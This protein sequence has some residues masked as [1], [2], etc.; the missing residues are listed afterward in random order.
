MRHAR[1][2]GFHLCSSSP[3]LRPF[4]PSLSL[5]NPI[6]TQ[7]TIIKQ[8]SR[9]LKGYS[10]YFE[11]TDKINWDFGLQN[12]R[13]DSRYGWIV[14]AMDVCSFSTWDLTLFNS[15]FG[16]RSNPSFYRINVFLLPLP[17]SYYVT[18][19]AEQTDE[20]IYIESLVRAHATH[21]CSIHDIAKNLASDL[22]AKFPA[23]K[24]ARLEFMPDIRKNLKIHNLFGAQCTF[25]FYNPSTHVKAPPVGFDSTYQIFTEWQIPISPQSERVIK[26]T[27]QTIESSGSTVYNQT[28]SFQKFRTC[29]S[30]GQVHPTFS[31]HE[32][33]AKLPEQLHY[34][35]AE[36]E[37]LLL[38]RCLFHLAD[39]QSPCKRLLT[40]SVAM[41]DKNPLHNEARTEAAKIL[42]ENGQEFVNQVF[43]SCT[44][45]LDRQQYEQSQRNL[46]SSEFLNGRHRAYLALGSNLGNRVELIESAV[47]EISKRGLVVLRTSALYE[48]KPMYLENQET[49]INGACEVCSTV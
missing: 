23:V 40:A 2:F 27:L 30:F 36:S 33:V 24:E 34:D 5:L 29:Y 28:P 21:D 44:V 10:S 26:L 6:R 8:V 35:R 22:L 46:L 43:T 45:R 1:S 39:K 9:R 14:D 7:R 15:R 49:F 20:A 3:I 18:N 42:E 12:I 31:L 17:G 19:L 41:R 38:A 32:Q 48:T 16:I 25:V 11:G 47:R 13:L 37:A 4:R